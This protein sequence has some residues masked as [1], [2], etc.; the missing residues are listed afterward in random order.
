MNSLESILHITRDSVLA[1]NLL[2]IVNALKEDVKRLEKGEHVSAWAKYIPRNQF[3]RILA[4]LMFSSIPDPARPLT[5][6]YE[7]N[8]TVWSRIQ[9]KRLIQRLSRQWE[10]Q[11]VL[12][13]ARRRPTH[14]QK[15]FC[16]LKA[17]PV[18]D[19]VKTPLPMPVMMEKPCRF[20]KTFEALQ[21]LAPHAPEDWTSMAES[22]T[23]P[24]RSNMT[25][26]G[27][28]E[29]LDFSNMAVYDDGRIDLCKCGVGPKN[30][31]A[32]MAALENNQFFKHFLFG[33]NVSGKSGAE[34]IA[35]YVKRHPYR[36]D[37]ET[38]YLAGNDLN[39]EAIQIMCEALTSSKAL[40]ALWLKRNPVHTDGAQHLAKL[41]AAHQSLE[42][43]DLDNCGLLDDGVKVLCKGLEQNSS[44]RHLYLGANGIGSGGAAQLSSVLSEDHCSLESLFLSTN[45]FG[46][47]G[48]ILLAVGVRQNKSL[49]RLILSSNSIESVGVVILADAISSH[50]KLRTVCF[51]MYASTEDMGELPNRMGHEGAVAIAAMLH[52]NPRLQVLSV[53]H[54]ALEA[55]SMSLIAEA[56][57]VHPSL[58][59]LDL[60][61]YKVT[62]DPLLRARVQRQVLRNVRRIYGDDMSYQTF[63]RFYLHS[64]RNIPQIAHIRSIYRTADFTRQKRR[65]LVKHWPQGKINL[66]DKE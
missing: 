37:F 9:C 40:K 65:Q 46:N 66:V 25:S 57:A 43:L 47:D 45:R 17:R 21:E 3:I 53:A 49:Q 35:E 61:E 2:L 14:E 50:P 24:V 30:I 23:L 63:L 5:P 38:W 42:I 62:Y 39:A 44:L 26:Y 7:Q 1:D 8:L 64:Y 56:A 54:N 16:V 6:E 22:S 20:L 19:Q 27:S 10:L 59:H 55:T 41:L 13:V 34:A 60:I 32:L 11:Q 29:Y 48:A 4:P 51:G 18:S 15:D 28:Q 33:N 52:A 58:L 31:G 36:G 12:Q